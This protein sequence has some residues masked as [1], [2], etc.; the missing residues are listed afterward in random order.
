[1]AHADKF[2]VR[3]PNPEVV[4]VAGRFICN[5]AFSAAAD[6]AAAR[7][8]AGKGFRVRHAAAGTYTLFHKSSGAVW[9]SGG[10][11]IRSAQGTVRSPRGGTSFGS[12]NQSGM[13][14]N[15]VD[16]SNNVVDAADTDVVAFWA[17][18][19]LSKLPAK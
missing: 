16:G 7:I 15:I 8:L 11:V 5:G 17:C 4:L 13:D 2:P 14:M 1:M 6:I 9:L 19:Q 10:F 12:A 3:T 18:F